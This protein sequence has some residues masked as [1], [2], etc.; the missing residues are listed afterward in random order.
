MLEKEIK[1]QLW[2]Q[3]VGII[4]L[5]FLS[6]KLRMLYQAWDSIAELEYHVDRSHS[7]FHELIIPE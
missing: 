5:T 3:N 7:A 2:E 6:F 4:Q 1:S